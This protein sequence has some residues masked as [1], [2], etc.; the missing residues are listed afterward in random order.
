MITF[1]LRCEHTPEDEI[2]VNYGD[3]NTNGTLMV[4]VWSESKYQANSVQLDV[5]KVVELRNHL[6]ELLEGL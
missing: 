3:W 2:S 6:N 1:K 5:D 4:Y